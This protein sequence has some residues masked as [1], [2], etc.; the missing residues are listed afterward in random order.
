[1]AKWIVELPDVKVRR[2]TDFGFD[3]DDIMLT[4][5]SSVGLDL[6]TI[7]LYWQVARCNSKVKRFGSLSTSNSEV[8][9]SA[10]GKLGKQT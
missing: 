5:V 1:M 6:N 3:Q 2:R 7:D 9:L 10:S 4:L 8:Q